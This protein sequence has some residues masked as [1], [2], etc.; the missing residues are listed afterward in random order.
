MK[1]AVPDTASAARFFLRELCSGKMEFYTTASTSSDSISKLSSVPSGSEDFG[2]SAKDAVE[3]LNGFSFPVDR[4]FSLV[5][6]PQEL[7]EEEIEEENS[8]QDDMSK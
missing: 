3:M 4:I 2:V 7:E 8:N 6:A 1:G 5:L